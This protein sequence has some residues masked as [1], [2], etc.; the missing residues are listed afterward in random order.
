M[1]NYKS[2]I[3]FSLLFFCFIILSFIA[4]AQPKPFR[5]VGY[6]VNW[7][8]TKAYARTL[9]YSKLTHINY[10]FTNVKNL[11]GELEEQGSDLD[12]LINRAHEKNVKVL[13]SLGGG[14]M[15]ATTKNT[16]FTL[17]STAENRAL[18]THQ[19]ALYIAKYKL[20]G[21]DVDLEGDVIN[22]DYSAFIKQLTDTLHPKNLLVT[23]ALNGSGSDNFS[24][25]TI[26]LFDWINIMSYDATGSWTPNN[27]GQHASYEYAVEGINSW[28]ARGARKDQLCVG[29][30]F[31]AHAFLNDINL[32]Y[33]EYRDI[34]KRYPNAYQQD[35]VGYI[36]YYNGIPT[37][38]QKTYMALAQ[39]GG[40]MIWALQHDATRDKS[41]LNAINEVVT[42]YSSNNIAPIIKITNPTKDTVINKSDLPIS[43]EYNDTEN[44]FMKSN[45]YINEIK[46][47][48]LPKG[49]KTF[50]LQNLSNGTY[51]I[52][53]E[54]IDN[55]Y[56]SGSDTIKLT[57]NNIANDA[58]NGIIKH[59]P[60]KIEAE[61]YNIGGQSISYNDMTINNSGN[62]Y[63]ADGVD[64]ESCL[65][66][67]MGYDLG[68]VSAG[69]W[70]DYTVE[71]DSTFFYDIE[72]RTA[73]P[74]S[75]KSI[76]ISSNNTSIAENVAITN[77]GSWQKWSSVYTRKV[78]LEKGAQTLRI[79]FN[80]G[81]F[82]L[83]YFKITPSK[84]TDI[85]QN[86]VNSITLFP[87]PAT[88]ELMISGLNNNIKIVQADIIDLNGK[89]LL[90]QKT[91]SKTIDISTL[92]KGTYLLK[93][94][95]NSKT[96]Y[97]KFQ[98]K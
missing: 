48:E 5:V 80:S 36:V 1:N 46:I 72:F 87:N 49:T 20:D 17:F 76:S 96:E 44:S 69:E 25:E 4:Q 10:A 59:I 27:P 55:Q 16:Y 84:T 35:T 60:G 50:N 9:D 53:V 33:I 32:D 89:T 3:K 56:E 85:Q 58:F 77:T 13:I 68:W 22:K 86:T 74:N 21:I 64:I 71:V 8:D 37:I 40:V 30:P 92:Q 63:R 94:V 29:L 23:A 61:D 67:G 57:V 43:F 28:S 31:Y 7:Y 15:S 70:L 73:T 98:K 65:D 90:V 81:D 11:N 2:T 51:T 6:F 75:G 95:F 24:N 39:A 45:I 62:T 52:V 82:N 26:A 18:F 78:K 38:K 97:L 41:L 79:K 93:L 54:G 66:K 12:T 34:L 42:T 83:N 91:A 88:S 19:I 14:A 47:N